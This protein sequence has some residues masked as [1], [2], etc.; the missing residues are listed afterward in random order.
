MQINNYKSKIDLLQ[1][2]I[3]SVN[4]QNEQYKKKYEDTVRQLQDKIEEINRLK[5][6]MSN[7]TSNQSEV[8][9]YYL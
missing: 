6:A 1:N 7:L 5:R 8:L 9:L 4:K 3:D 2:S